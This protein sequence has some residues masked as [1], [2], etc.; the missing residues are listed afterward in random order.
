MNVNKSTAIAGTLIHL[1]TASSVGSGANFT[2]T[3]N[4]GI[5][6]SK[7]LISSLTAGQLTARSNYFMT[8]STTQNVTF[9]SETSNSVTLNNGFFAA[10]DMIVVGVI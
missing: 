3:H 1:G 5:T 4:K 6:F 9:V 2:I 8:N 10:A 7:Y